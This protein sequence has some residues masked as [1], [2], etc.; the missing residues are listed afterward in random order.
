MLITIRVGM[1]KYFV[2]L[3]VTLLILYFVEYH[4]MELIFFIK[5][6]FLRKIVRKSP[7]KILKAIYF[8]ILF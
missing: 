3:S 2:L 1:R 4:H 5:L 8:F 6:L 7:V